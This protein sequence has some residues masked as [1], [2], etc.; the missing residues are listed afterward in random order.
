M[1]YRYGKDETDIG[2]KVGKTPGIPDYEILTYEK[3]MR[4][5][6]TF[7]VFTLLYSYSQIVKA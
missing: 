5:T 7:M 1:E 6:A 4:L 2:E 3:Y